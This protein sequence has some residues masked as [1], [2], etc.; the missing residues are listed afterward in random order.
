MHK[1]IPKRVLVCGLGSIGKRYCNLIRKEW[2]SIEIAALRSPQQ[3]SKT[4]AQAP[5]DRC[6]YSLSEA[7][8]WDPDSAIICTP[9]SLHLEQAL[10]ISQCGIPIL[11]EKPIG[12]GEEALS[13]WNKLLEAGESSPIYL[14]YILRQDP[15]SSYIKNALAGKAI[16]RLITAEFYCGSW[17]PEWRPEADYR[18]TVSS[19]RLLGGGVLLELSHELDMARYLFGAIEP[20][21]ATIQN[22]SSLKTDAEDTARI[23]VRSEEDLLIGINLDF[24]TKP[25]KR[26]VTVRGEQGELSWDL[27]VGSIRLR[28]GSNE[29]VILQLGLNADD[30]FLNQLNDFWRLP[31]PGQSKLCDIR[32]GLMVLDLIRNVRAINTSWL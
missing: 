29:E 2:P 11:I 22:I 3:P 6:F 14:G 13:D 27:I 12:T 15:C 26:F 28:T 32:D 20:L 31:Q 24:C 9:A 21:F 19:Q 1:E 4:P 17:L 23:V 7:V 8:K 10:F 16:G 25:A 18:K 5:I 30:R